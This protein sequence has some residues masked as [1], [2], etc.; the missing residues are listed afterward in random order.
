MIFRNVFDVNEQNYQLKNWKREEKSEKK[1]G[2]EKRELV[3]QQLE[4]RE[5]GFKLYEH[6]YSWV[7]N[8]IS[9][10]GNT[11]AI[12]QWSSNGNIVD[13]PDH[14]IVVNEDPYAIRINL[15]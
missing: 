10:T 8:A 11:S 2:T 4:C 7:R 14:S 3:S 5:L 1:G 13:K 6:A 12:T 15:D 9:I